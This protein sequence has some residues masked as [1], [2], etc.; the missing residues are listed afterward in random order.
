M[1]RRE[2]KKQQ[3]KKSRQDRLRQEKHLRQAQ[4][5]VGDGA[6]WDDDDDLNQVDSDDV[7]TSSPLQREE[8]LR[9]LHEAIAACGIE[10]EEELQEFLATY[11]PQRRGGSADQ[12]DPNAEAQQ[13]AYRALEQ[14]ERGLS[15][16]LA[17]QALQLDPDCIDALAALAYATSTSVDQFIA[18]LENALTAGERALGTDFF[19]ANRGHFWGVLETRPYMRTRAMLAELLRQDGR[20]PQAIAHYEALLELNPNDNQGNRDPLL[21][22]YLATDAL[23]KTRRLL[24]QYGDDMAVFTWGRVLERYLSG[25]VAGAAT[26]LRKARQLNRHVE[27]FLTGVKP[28]PAVPPNSYSMGSESE[29]IHAA[30]YLRPAF[31]KHAAALVAPS[32]PRT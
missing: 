32:S 4:P 15:A 14:R 29:A 11:D 31:A 21:G 12:R 19:T 1:N 30:C 8:M 6:A 16:K 20:L 13:L 10:T 7:I 27:P 17:R 22:C 2:R 23:D 24:D 5:S 25:D 9:G 3:K 18:G 26:A 28:L